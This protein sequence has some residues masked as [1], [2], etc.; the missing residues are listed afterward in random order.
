M[1]AQVTTLRELLE[2]RFPGSVPL[3]QHVS[4]GIPTGIVELDRVLPGGGLPRGRLIVWRPGGGATAVLRAAC[5]A[6]VERGE[7]A[8]W[9]DGRGMMS[10][11]FWGGETALFRPR[12]RQQALECAEELA[13][14]GGVGL[15]VVTG[16]RSEE[17]ERVRLSRAVR[18][19]GG[20][21]AMLEPGGFMASLRIASRI[22]PDG[23]RWRCNAFGEPGEVEAVTIQARVRALGWSKETEFLLPVSGHELRLSVESSLVDRR[24]ATR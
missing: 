12:G 21:L 11:P 9:V 1:S 2:R 20:V 17:A 23:Y 13:R 24:G 5:R 16:A 19:G 7:R 6:A 15:V 22:R 4:G 8:A 3:T 18:E 14:C 10:G